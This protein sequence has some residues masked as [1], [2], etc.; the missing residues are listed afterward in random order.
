MHNK[1]FISANSEPKKFGQNFRFSAKFFW[2]GIGWNENFIMQ[3]AYCD[4]NLFN[5]IFSFIIEKILSVKW[6]FFQKQGFVIFLTGATESDFFE[7]GRRN[8]MTIASKPHIPFLCE[9]FFEVR[10]TLIMLCDVY[11]HC[12][13]YLYAKITLFMID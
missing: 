4:K 5:K 2:L 11:I 8:Y 10:S 1:I 9:D 12:S 13:K 6:F 3:L 7:I